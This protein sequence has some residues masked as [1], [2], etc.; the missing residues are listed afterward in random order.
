MNIRTTSF[1]SDHIIFL[2]IGVKTMIYVT[3][4]AWYAVVK[5]LNIWLKFGIFGR[6]YLK[7]CLYS[8]WKSLTRNPFQIKD[9]ATRA[10]PPSNVVAQ[11]HRFSRQR[12]VAWFCVG[13]QRW[14]CRERERERESLKQTDITPSLSYVRHG[15]C[16]HKYSRSFFTAKWNG[17]YF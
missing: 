3:H 9:D 16:Y 7:I 4:Q 14:L 2:F 5:Y 12:S 6:K 17:W 8:I 10:F 11:T 15:P 13:V 1:C